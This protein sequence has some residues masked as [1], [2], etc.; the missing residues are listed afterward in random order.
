MYGEDYLN[1][2]IQFFFYKQQKQGACGLKG[3]VFLYGWAQL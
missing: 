2:G 3:F 1:R